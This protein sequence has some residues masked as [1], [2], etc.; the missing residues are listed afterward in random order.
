V[1]FVHGF[2]DLNGAE[3]SEPVDC[4]EAG[5]PGPRAGSEPPPGRGPSPK[6]PWQAAGWLAVVGLVTVAFNQRPAVGS[7]P[8][9]LADLG[10]SA[11]AE[12]ILVTIPV[13]CF[14]LGALAG[15]R[16]R[17]VFGQEWAVFVLLAALTVFIALRA[18]VLGWMLLPATIVIGL[19]IA[20]LNV[21]MPAFIKQRFPD[22]PGTTTAAYVA[23]ATLGPAVA[24]GLTVPVFHA[25]GGS[26]T[27]ALGIWALPAVAALVAWAPQLALAGRS[28]AVPA[29]L[30]AGAEWPAAGPPGRSGSSQTRP[31]AHRPIWR[32][33]LAWQVMAYM[34]IGSLVFYGPLSW[35]PE[36]YQSRGLNAATA[37][38]LLLVMN[39]LGMIGSTFAPLV[40]RRRR[41]LRLGVIVF[42]AI[43]L[44]G[45]VGLL[46][47]SNG[48]AYFWMAVLGLG[49]GAQFGLALLLIVL[50]AADDDVAARLSAMSQSGGY[51]IA[52]TG[53]LFMGAL[54]SVTAGWSAP[55][56]FLVAANLVGMALGY[57][58]A[59]DR[60][61]AD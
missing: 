34:G 54:H 4:P 57:L 43:A 53:P 11:S 1:P 5:G 49:Q 27:W 51:L 37:G 26:V 32:H 33:P 58:A 30:R 24:A 22:R 39:F 16:I 31:V 44:V 13:L 6:V 45:F 48:A 36:I 7:I 21:L 59:K 12:S 17:R 38:Y 8:P 23:S 2:D 29:S 25:F 18:V 20:N 9:V 3:A 50:R 10:L 15:P 47:G 60:V 35:L 42:G 52:A 28:S 55:I 19:C 41:D 14:G 46:V 61:I 56:V 40:M